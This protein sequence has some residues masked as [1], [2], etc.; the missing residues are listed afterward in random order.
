[1]ER[2]TTR[3][4]VTAVLATVLTAIGLVL[5]TAAPASAQTEGYG[6]DRPAGSTAVDPP[7]CYRVLYGPLDV[8]VVDTRWC[9]LDGVI[10]P[11]RSIC[12]A[13]P[14]LPEPYVFVDCV[15][16]R[17][18]APTG[19]R[20]DVATRAVICGNIPDF[21]CLYYVYDIHAAFYP[22]GRAETVSESYDAIPNH[23]FPR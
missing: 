23:G 9:L 12:Q 1:M 19:E 8:Y 2:G 17:Q 5:V 14:F 3:R 6:P 7:G 13:D 10:E 20:L 18:L 22:D 11:N 15:V 21:G 4:R 16:E